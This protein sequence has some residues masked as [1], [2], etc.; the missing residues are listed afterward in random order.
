MAPTRPNGPAH[1]PFNNHSKT[2]FNNHSM[3]IQ[4][5]FNDHSI[6]IPLLRLCCSYCG[7]PW[8]DAPA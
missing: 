4:R 1:G 8:F 7:M 3:T 5:P 6:T 2:T